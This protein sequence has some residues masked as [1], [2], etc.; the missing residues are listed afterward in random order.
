MDQKIIDMIEDIV[1]A[2]AIGGT[3]EAEPSRRHGEC[4]RHSS[5]G[6]RPC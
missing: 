5:N 6:R 2:K 3:P 1:A 4:C